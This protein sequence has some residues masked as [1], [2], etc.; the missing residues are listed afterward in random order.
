MLFSQKGNYG[1]NTI[2]QSGSIAYT[3]NYRCQIV[4]T[5]YRLLKTFT[6]LVNC[7]GQVFPTTFSLMF[8]IVEV[9]NRFPLIKSQ[10]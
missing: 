2:S 9:N 7:Q 5:N 1:E 4:E 3:N 10:P 6:F 8:I